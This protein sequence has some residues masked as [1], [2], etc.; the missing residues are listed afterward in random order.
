MKTAVLTI[1]ALAAL[2]GSASAQPYTPPAKGPAIGLR[3][4][5]AVD[6]TVMAASDSFKALFGSGEVTGAG[7]GGEVDLGKHLF[8]RIADTRATR[9]GSRVFVDDNGGTFPLGIPL[10]VTM[11]PIEAGAGW[12]FAT[13]G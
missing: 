10:T 3:A 8:V 2:A 6:A 13:R 4:Y 5:G 12:R 9:T 11:T 1:A 7:G